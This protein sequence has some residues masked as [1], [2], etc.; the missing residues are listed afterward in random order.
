MKTYRLI[1]VRAH[2]LGTSSPGMHPSLATVEPAGDELERQV[3]VYAADGWEVQGSPWAEGSSLCVLMVR[4]PA[5]VAKE[6]PRP[7]PPSLPKAGA[8]DDGFYKGF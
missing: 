1:R 5:P 6:G 4:E 3:N 8:G 2:A 7:L